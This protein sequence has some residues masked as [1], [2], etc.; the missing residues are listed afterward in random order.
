M[1]IELYTGKLPW[2]DCC[3][4]KGVSEED[5]AIAK[6]KKEMISSGALVAGLPKPFTV[7]MNHLLTLEFPTPP[8]YV[9]CIG[10]FKKYYDELISKDKDKEQNKEWNFCGFTDT[11]L[12]TPTLC[13]TERYDTKED[14]TSACVIA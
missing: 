10:A 8:D 11:E 5:D 6:M 12:V 4:R 2:D 3:P 9:L 13:T 7:F 14:N 1:G